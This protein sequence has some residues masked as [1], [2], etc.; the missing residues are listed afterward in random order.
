MELLNILN[1]KKN[2]VIA[3][4]DP[5]WSDDI[6]AFLDKH[7]NDILGVKLHSDIYNNPARATLQFEI[8]PKIRELFPDI[9][10]HCLNNS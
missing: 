3:S 10:S 5:E 1:Q 8:G 2:N 7:A 4:L 6:F 9:K